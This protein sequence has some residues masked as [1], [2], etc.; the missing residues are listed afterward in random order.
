[1]SLPPMTLPKKVKALPLSPPQMVK[2]SQQ[3]FLE[4]CHQ[5]PSITKFKS[6]VESCYIPPSEIKS[7]NSLYTHVYMH[8]QQ[9]SGH[10]LC[11][12]FLMSGNFWLYIY[13][14][15]FFFYLSLFISLWSSH[16]VSDHQGYW[17]QCPQTGRGHSCFGTRIRKCRKALGSHYSMQRLKG[18]FVFFLA[19]VVMYFFDYTSLLERHGFRTVRQSSEQ[20]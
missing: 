20:K 17:V 16:S 14:Q 11:V 5:F 12:W 4:H 1:M 7:P 9:K 15:F 10:C 19:C 8:V 18:F 6:L 13:I 3:E 2:A